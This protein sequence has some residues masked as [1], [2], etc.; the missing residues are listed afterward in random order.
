[1]ADN[2]NFTG[3]DFK[4][5]PDFGLMDRKAGLRI[6]IGH[7]G[8]IPNEY[9]EIENKFGGILMGIQSAGMDQDRIDM[10]CKAMVDECDKEGIDLL[11]TKSDRHFDS[12][13]YF[14]G[15]LDTML[16]AVLMRRVTPPFNVGMVLNIMR[17]I[18]RMR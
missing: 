5:L 4:G 17:A 9:S 15:D 13:W 16:N 12:Q 7:A 18:E 1:M 10:A 11:I 2:I 6:M 14:F 3:L 8:R